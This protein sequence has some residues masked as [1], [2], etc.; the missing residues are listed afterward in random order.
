MKFSY[1]WLML[2]LV[3]FLVSLV[4]FLVSPTVETKNRIILTTNPDGNGSVPR[5]DEKTFGKATASSAI[6][7]QSEQLVQQDNNKTVESNTASTVMAF[8]LLR[9]EK[10]RLFSEKQKRERS[11]FKS[12]VINKPKMELLTALKGFYDMEGAKDTAFREEMQKE[13][14]AFIASQPQPVKDQLLP[15]IAKDEEMRNFLAERYAMNS[16]FFDK[17]ASD[18]AM[19]GQALHQAFQAFTRSQADAIKQHAQEQYNKVTSLPTGSL[20]LLFPNQMISGMRSI[21][22]WIVRLPLLMEQTVPASPQNM[23]NRVDNDHARDKAKNS[24]PSKTSER[25]PKGQAKPKKRSHH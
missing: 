1:A 16:A 22:S 13:N 20:W 9:Q 4:Y 19:E 24:S 15:I 17:M 6:T 2:L 5:N 21:Y 12:A 18:P 10:L 25:E 14:L 8:H 7:S 23:K 3:L 11:E